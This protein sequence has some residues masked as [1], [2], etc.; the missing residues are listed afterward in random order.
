MNQQVPH[1]D[2]GVTEVG[3]EN[4]FAEKVIE[5]APGRVTPEKCPTLVPGTV[6]LHVA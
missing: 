3:A 1:G 5:L 2:V 6:K 4:G